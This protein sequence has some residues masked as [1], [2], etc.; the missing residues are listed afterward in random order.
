MIVQAMRRA[1]Q[2]L[3]AV[4]AAILVVGAFAASPTPSRAAAGEVAS[5]LS[6][7]D[8]IDSAGFHGI[9]TDMATAT[10]VP[11]RLAGTMAKL[12]VYAEATHWP[13]ALDE[14]VRPFIG[15]LTAF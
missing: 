9:A 3:L 15:D 8:M 6:I 13:G 4:A 10:G 14:E 7:I 1:R 2:S 11:P 12:L 5:A